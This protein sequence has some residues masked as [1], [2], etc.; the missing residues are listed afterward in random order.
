MKRMI[1][2]AAV[3]MLSLT[4]CNSG[5]TGNSTSVTPDVVPEQSAG[6]E[7]STA[8]ELATVDMLYYLNLGD[9][10]I[11]AACNT[12]TGK[13]SL[14]EDYY[15]V[16]VDAAE[17]YNAQGKKISLEELTRGCPIRIAWPGMVM[18]SYPGQISAVTVTA[19]SDE[20]DP[21]V[22]PEDQIPSIDGGPKWWEPETVT[23]VPEMSI[24]YRNDLG[25]ITALVE[26]RHGSWSYGQEDSQGN[27]SGGASSDRKDGQKPQEWTFPEQGILRRQGEETVKLGFSPAPQSI[28]VTAY[29]QDDPEDQGTPV[30]L[31]ADNNLTLLD[32]N[33]VYAVSVQWDGQY[34][35]NAV[36]GFLVTE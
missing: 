20:A 25:E 18:E 12:E 34:H 17:I 7:S 27:L 5:A 16:H 9:G 28:S 36:Y 29:R 31:D 19:L 33:Y 23:Q 21:L 24:E 30:A 8:E 14:G 3:L 32:G 4:A 15:V 1:L 11:M 22:P 6:G 13:Q 2:L 10:S 35:G 26:C